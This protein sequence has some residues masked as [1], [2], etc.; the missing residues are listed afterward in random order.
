M[1]LKDQAVFHGGIA[2]CMIS[3]LSDASPGGD[4]QKAHTWLKRL[5]NTVL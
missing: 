1:R 3:V 2:K 4:V 5:L